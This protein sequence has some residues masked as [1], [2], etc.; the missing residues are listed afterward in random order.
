M[1][2]EVASADDILRRRGRGFEVVADGALRE[3]F[4]CGDWRFWVTAAGRTEDILASSGGNAM[5]WTDAGDGFVVLESQFGGGPC[6]VRL[7]ALWKAIEQ[8]AES[9]GLREKMRA[10]AA[11]WDRHHAAWLADRASCPADSSR[12][13]CSDEAHEAWE[14]QRPGP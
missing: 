1:T 5:N 7:D 12:R 2:D 9:T 4:D 8:I 14:R 13:N 6:R 3:F 11:D 10:S